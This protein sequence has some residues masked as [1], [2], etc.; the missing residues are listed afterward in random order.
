MKLGLLWLATLAMIAGGCKDREPVP[1]HILVV[2]AE[3]A[4]F[5]LDG[6]PMAQDQVLSELEALANRSRTSPGGSARMVVS[7]R[8]ESGVAYDRIVELIDQ[9]SALGIN[10]IETGSR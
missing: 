2:R 3:G 8:Q 6:Q 5:V 10:K 9:C 7:I 4:G 1:V